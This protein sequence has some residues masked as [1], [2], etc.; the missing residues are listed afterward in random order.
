MNLNFCAANTIFKA[1]KSEGLRARG[2]LEVYGVKRYGHRYR[3]WNGQ[4]V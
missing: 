4:V 2:R 1:H 3:T